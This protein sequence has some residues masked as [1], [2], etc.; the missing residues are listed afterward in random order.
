[1]SKKWWPLVVISASVVASGCA[2]MVDR[3]DPPQRTY[4]AELIYLKTIHE[5]ERIPEPEL[6]LMLMSEYMNGNR[7]GEGVE[8]FESLVSKADTAPGQRALY[9]ACLGALRAAD[10]EHVP[11]LLAAALDPIRWRLHHAVHRSAVRSGRQPG[12]TV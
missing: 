12:R 5:H 6:T 4:N 7:A 1:M 2:T 3:T 10:A 11:L 9:R 8:F